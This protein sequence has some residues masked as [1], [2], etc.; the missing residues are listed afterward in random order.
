MIMAGMM[1]LNYILPLELV[2][3]WLPDRSKG[4]SY[5]FSSFQ[6]TEIAVIGTFWMFPYSRC[7]KSLFKSH[8]RFQN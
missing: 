1:K 5:L 7:H 6:D 2:K 4:L 8:K 3:F